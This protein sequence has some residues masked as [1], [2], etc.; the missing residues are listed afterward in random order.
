M[1]QQNILV[2]LFVGALVIGGG[3]FYAGMQYE[4]SVTPAAT[5]QGTGGFRGTRGFDGGGKNAGGGGGF[6]NGEII[7]KDDTSMT[8]KLRDGGSKIV[9]FSTSTTIGKMTNGSL[10]DIAVGTDV[11]V[12]GIA[13][14]DGSVTATMIQIRPA[15]TVIPREPRPTNAP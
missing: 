6:A 1:P 13:N 5:Q 10:E 3:S 4:K 11:S 2:P 7:S 8:I 9:F 15:G 14:S 12:N